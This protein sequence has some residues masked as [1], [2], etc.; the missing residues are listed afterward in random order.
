MDKRRMVQETVFNGGE[1]E[2]DG[3]PS[4]DAIGFLAWFQERIDR[5][6]AEH[7]MTAKIS[8]ESQGGYYGE[9]HAHIEITYQRPETD[10]QFAARLAREERERAYK[11]I[12]QERRER[13]MIDARGAL[14]RTKCH[15]KPNV[16]AKATT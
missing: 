12:E 5:I 6:P 10:E 3:W 13:Q 1:H 2:R 4:E 7:Q 8:L 14:S 11:A 15:Q 16:R 9:H